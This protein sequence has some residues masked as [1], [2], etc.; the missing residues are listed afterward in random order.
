MPEFV[1]QGRDDPRFQALDSFTQAYIEAAIFTDEEQLGIDQ[2]TA[3]L[4]SD[5]TFAAIVDDCAQFQRWANLDAVPEHAH[6]GRTGIHEQ[7]G[8]DFWMTRNG[9]GVGFWDGD[10]IEPHANRLDNLSKRFGEFDLYRGDD[11]QIHH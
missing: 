3:E 7:A 4:L 10:W 8:H 5:H 2:P 9:H 1:L 11:G 6:A